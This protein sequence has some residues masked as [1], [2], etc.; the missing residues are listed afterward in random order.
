LTLFLIH[1]YSTSFEDTSLDPNDKRSIS[2]QILKNKGLTPHRKKEQRN[3]RVKHRNKYE[4]A[5][6]KIKSVKR[7]FT[8]LE[9]SY[10]GEKTGIKTGLARSVK[11]N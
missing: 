1:S 3:P 11:F 9:G 4:Q 8:R 5:K 10:G 6:K 7:V 2:W